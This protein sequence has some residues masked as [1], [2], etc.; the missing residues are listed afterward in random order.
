MPARLAV[1]AVLLLAGCNHVT[2]LTVGIPAT[3]PRTTRAAVAVPDTA[4][5]PLPLPSTWEVPDTFSLSSLQRPDTPDSEMFK[6]TL[7]KSSA[8]EARVVGAL[9]EV[10]NGMESERA[11]LINR[12]AQTLGFA[13]IGIWSQQT[14]ERYG[15]ALQN[16]GLVVDISPE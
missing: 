9:L 15:N 4:T 10:V 12:K 7:F 14:A 2:A 8:A 3:Q 16:R 13:L 5:K 6:L 11:E 1:C